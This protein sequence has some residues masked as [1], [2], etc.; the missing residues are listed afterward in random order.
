[1]F[2]ELMNNSILNPIIISRSYNNLSKN[3]L[4]IESSI[5][6]GIMPNNN[7]RILTQSRK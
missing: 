6:I 2:V 3:I 4:Q 7:N 5:D 1:M